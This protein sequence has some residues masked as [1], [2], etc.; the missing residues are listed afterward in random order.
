MC[1]RNVRCTINNLMR[2]KTASSIA[3]YS[4]DPPCFPPPFA[5]LFPLIPWSP[6][7]SRLP[8][9]ISLSRSFSLPNALPAKNVSR[10]EVR[11]GREDHV[12]GLEFEGG[13]EG[14]PPSSW[15]GVSSPGICSWASKYS[16]GGLEG[17]STWRTTETKTIKAISWDIKAL[18]K[19]PVYLPR[20]IMVM[21]LLVGYNGNV[22]IGRIVNGSRK[23]SCTLGGSDAWGF[24]VILTRYI[25]IIGAKTRIANDNLWFLIYHLCWQ[26][27]L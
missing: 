9:P 12:L 13:R 11:F 15:L 4:S 5:L 7:L 20:V 23:Y 24:L 19:R 6:L 27:V 2:E 21:L 1:L 17:E 18:Y 16:V 8:W 22:L 10:V 26:W 25:E 3:L 14:W